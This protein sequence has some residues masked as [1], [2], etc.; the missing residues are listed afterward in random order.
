MTWKP[1]GMRNGN[2]KNGERRELMKQKVEE[3]EISA[4]QHRIIVYGNGIGFSVFL[5]GVPKILKE[6]ATEL[7]QNLLEGYDRG[8]AKG[9]EASAE[10][11]IT[12]DI[13]MEN[14]QYELSV[15]LYSEEEEMEIITYEIFPG[16]E[17][18]QALKRYALQQVNQYLFAK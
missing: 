3:F 4:N 1:H 17:H 6:K 11:C 10:L 8:G 14:C 18:Y 13:Y 9:K 12:S 15:Y 7:I 16:T 2:K 5:P